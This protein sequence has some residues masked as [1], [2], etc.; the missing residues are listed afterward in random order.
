[1]TASHSHCRDFS[2]SELLRA[3]VA[4][5][6]SGLP[7]I[8]AGMPV[9][10][11]TGLTRRSFVARTSGLALAVFGGAALAPRAFEAGIAEAA[12][13]APEAPVLVSV[14]LSG[15]LDALTALAPVND[16][17]YQAWRPELRV[18][19][20]DGALPLAGDGR[21]FWHPSLAPLRALHESGKLTV[22]PSVGYDDPNQ[23]HFTSR[24]Y[25]EI[26]RLDPHGRVGWMG[27]YLDRHGSATNPLQ[28][29]GLDYT[30]APS[31]APDANPVACVPDPEHY[32]FWAEHVW[33]AGIRTKLM[34]AF[35]GL[36]ELGTGDPGLGLARAATRMTTKLATDLGGLQGT[37]TW[38]STATY[39]T[40]HAF[41]RRLQVLAEMID[42]GMPLRCV[43]LTAN[44][45][46]DTHANQEGSLPEDMALLAQS[47]AAF[48]ADLEGRGVA[49]RVLVH[50]WSEFGRRP[51]ENGSGTDHGAGGLG[52]VMGTRAAGGIVGEW[53]GL[54]DLHP[55]G[56][57]R[58]SVDYRTVY[59][60][61]IDQWL[62]VDPDP[63][64]PGAGAL[65][66][67][68]L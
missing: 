45:G 60:A 7:D 27:R 62:G 67:L 50:V 63:I 41:P 64:V 12:A 54:D 37:R 58:H 30:L 47:L 35:G 1:M 23:S 17:K 16:P 39:P 53:R 11:G 31:L 44:G 9:P 24:H 21:L 10:A 19:E 13:A 32:S 2:R 51:R 4:G 68:V 43:A 26:G 38:S 56:N 59:R 20:A 8:E 14:F 22:I 28:G 46:Y 66:Q 42:R 36:G 49:D 52:L 55:D 33:D 25:W 34:D 40:S 6:G 61:L 5:A 65:P 29:L 57:L 48:Q 18:T 3:G 15:G